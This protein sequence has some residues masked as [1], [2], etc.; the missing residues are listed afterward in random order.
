MDATPKSGVKLSEDI[1]KKIAEGIALAGQM[2]HQYGVSIDTV[3]EMVKKAVQENA[4]YILTDREVEDP[5]KVRTK[6]L[7]KAM[8]D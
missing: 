2:L 4:L 5:I 3:G 8:P 1:E 7:L 6:A